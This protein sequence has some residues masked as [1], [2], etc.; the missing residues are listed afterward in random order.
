MKVMEHTIKVGDVVK[1]SQKFKELPHLTRYYHEQPM[2]VEE[3]KYNTHDD[4]VTMVYM[5][6]LHNPNE[7]MAVIA[8]LLEVDHAYMRKERLG[9]LLPEL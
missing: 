1:L 7:D 8:T 9:K 5:T 4:G 6:Y 3:V 2:V